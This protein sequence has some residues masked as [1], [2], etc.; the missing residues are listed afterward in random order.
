MT[1]AALPRTPQATTVPM[2]IAWLFGAVAF[3]L[4]VART[5]AQ[6]LGS[7]GEQLAA[8]HGQG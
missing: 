4:Q 3:L 8:G 7:A 2:R 6:A 1:E 5:G